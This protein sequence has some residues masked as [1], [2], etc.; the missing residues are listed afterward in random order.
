M[1]IYG[2][3]TSKE[4]VRHTKAGEPEAA[5]R[6]CDGFGGEQEERVLILSILSG[7][8]RCGIRGAKISAW[9]AAL[10]GSGAAIFGVSIRRLDA[11]MA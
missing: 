3:E 7:L 5:S 10:T 11:L 9:F 8:A 6:G 1:A 4:A 2:C